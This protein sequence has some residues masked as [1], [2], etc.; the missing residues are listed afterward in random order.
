MPP[1]SRVLPMLGA[2]VVG[3]GGYYI[4]KA[5]G[6]PSAAE[7]KF[8]ADMHRGAAKIKS[9]MPR[10]SQTDARQEGA[11][12]GKEIGSKIDEAV[13]QADKTYSSTKSQAEALAK[14]TKAE[15]LK[16]I[17]QFDRTVEQ[18]AAEAKSWFGSGNSK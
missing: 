15:A 17:D 10:S 13:S 3:I 9:E 8:E 7:K 5:G 16:K 18:K 11:Q 4:Y 1:K 14:D 12:Y 6:K 2:G